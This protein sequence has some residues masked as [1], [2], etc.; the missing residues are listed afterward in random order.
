M[1]SQP[2]NSSNFE[3]TKLIFPDRLIQAGA[4]K[5]EG[6]NREKEKIVYGKIWWKI[7]ISERDGIKKL[8]K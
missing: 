2:Q 6:G 7:I 8:N 1:Y 4:L 5:K 3:V